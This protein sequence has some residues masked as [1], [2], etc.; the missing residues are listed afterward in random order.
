MILG[1]GMGGLSQAMICT[2]SPV[3]IN[4]FAPR[5]RQT[6]WMGMYQGFAITGGVIGSVIGAM[7]ADNKDLGISDWFTWRTTLF[8]PASAFFK[9]ALTWFCLHNL[10]LDTQHVEKEEMKQMSEPLD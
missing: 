4:E 5:T 3:W 6:T 7:A 10:F 9:I 1:R 2:Y 8:F